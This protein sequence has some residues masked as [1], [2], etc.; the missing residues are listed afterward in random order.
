VNV[1]IY[2]S[3]GRIKSFCRRILLKLSLV[4][5]W[6]GGI[7][8]VRK[9]KRKC[10]K[11]LLLLVGAVFIYFILKIVFSILPVEVL[12]AKT[13][14]LEDTF[15]G[16]FIVLRQETVIPA[17]YRGYFV[18]VKNEGERV[19][20]DT[21]IGYLETFEGTSLEKTGSLPIKATV[22]GL[23]S[24]Q[25]DGLESFCNPEIWLQLD[26]EKLQSLPDF[27]IN[28]E[29]GKSSEDRKIQ[30]NGF[31]ESG[32][33][34]CKIVDNLDYSYF[35]LF[36]SGAYPERIKKGGNLKIR[37]D[38]NQDLILKGYVVDVFRKTGE[39][40]I[41]IKISNA[42]DYNFNRK[43]KGQ[44]ITT[45][46]KGIVLPE[47]VIT[48]KNGKFGVYLFKKGKATWKE[49][50]KIAQ[51]QGKVVL[52]G[53]SESDWVIADPQLVSEGKRV[54]RINK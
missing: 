37:L 27:A 35:Y 32:E 25:T 20:K 2:R 42:G 39:Y 52:S 41:L 18:K 4:D 13:S 53:L 3:L 45:S 40:G 30:G 29:K 9:R 17:P 33:G 5:P 23:V 28:S 19:A 31:V 21:I 36:G 51:L 48:E 38:N 46:Y 12:Q 7:F 54:S 24:Y 22:A 14:E 15:A 44:I 11:V 8:V 10:S 43:E 49:V 34:I 6:L 47:K 1:I 26:L 16:E 50:E